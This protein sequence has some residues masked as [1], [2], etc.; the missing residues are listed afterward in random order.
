MFETFLCISL[1]QWRF[2]DFVFD[3]SFNFP[4]ASFA[5]L[6]PTFFATSAFL[7]YFMDKCY[8]R[9]TATAD[10]DC[11]DSLRY[12]FQKPAQSAFAK[13]IRVWSWTSLYRTLAKWLFKSILQRFFERTSWS[14]LRDALL[15]G[16]PLQRVFVHKFFQITFTEY[17]SQS[18]RQEYLK[19]ADA[20]CKKIFG[21]HTTFFIGAPFDAF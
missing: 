20:S 3:D 9:L 6:F 16:L 10:V 18:S 15:T 1:K 4:T 12:F 13:K 17:F 11:L 7:A 21:E 5:K 14:D 2:A 8:K 19:F